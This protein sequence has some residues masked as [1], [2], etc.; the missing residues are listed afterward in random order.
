MKVETT[1]L[2]SLPLYLVVVGIRTQKIVVQ[3]RDRNLPN[4][5]W[6]YSI[7]HEQMKNDKISY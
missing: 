2:I 6:A 7:A 1:S 3:V 5:K 4:V